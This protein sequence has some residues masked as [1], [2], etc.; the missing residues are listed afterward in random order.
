MDCA[1]F[2]GKAQRS[3]GVCLGGPFISPDCV[4]CQLIRS[5]KA[6]PFGVDI[7]RCRYVRY[8]IERGR[9]G[10]D[11]NVIGPQGILGWIATEMAREG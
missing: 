1:E 7:N 3:A 9:I 8:L 6:L 10:W 5:G 11:D 4:Q 2:Q